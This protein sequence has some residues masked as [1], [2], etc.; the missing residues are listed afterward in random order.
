M[1]SDFTRF[2]SSTH[3]E[4]D[5]RRRVPHFKQELNITGH[6]KLPE[7]PLTLM[8]HTSYSNL[9]IGDRV[10]L[11]LRSLNLESELQKLSHDVTFLS[12]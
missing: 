4:S 3:T 2:T 8:T 1:C 10:L 5:T 6:I 11:V 7:C 9:V 12:A